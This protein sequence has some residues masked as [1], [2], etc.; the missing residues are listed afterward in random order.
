M[1]ALYLML[2]M[3][4]TQA[5]AGHRALLG[6]ASFGWLLFNLP[7]EARASGSD[8]SYTSFLTNFCNTSP[9]VGDVQRH[10]QTI[11]SSNVC[12]WWAKQ[13]WGSCVGVV[14][15]WARW[16][17]Q[18]PTG[19]VRSSTGGSNCVSTNAVLL[20]HLVL[21]ILQFICTFYSSI[22]YERSVVIK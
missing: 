17:E 9:H 1:T 3:N 6:A 19:K 2:C 12:G 21:V 22:L 5:I 10:H 20:T 16:E 15:S 14:S 4:V 11:M 13:T 18:Q 8:I 7:P